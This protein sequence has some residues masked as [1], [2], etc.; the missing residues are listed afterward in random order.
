MSQTVISPAQAVPIQAPATSAELP[1]TQQTSALSLII[2]CVLVGLNLR[3]ALAAIGPVVTL[4][5]QD[6]G[7]SFS[8]VA[9]L[10]LLPVLAM[11]IGC[12]VTLWLRR[13]ISLAHL[14]Q[15]ALALLLLANLLRLIEAGSLN[16]ALLL[17]TALLAG[18]GIAVIQAT[19]P[20]VIK[21]LA[22]WRA[23][24]A[25][26]AVL[27]VAAF[28][29]WIRW[30]ARTQIQPAAT[31]AEPQ[32]ATDAEVLSARPAAQSFNRYRLMSLVATFSMAA[33][34]YVCVLAWLPPF[35]I[36][37]GYSNTESGL[38]LG[39]LT[40]V[41]VI[42]GLLFP[43]WAAGSPDRR[44]VLF[45]VLILSIGGFIWL[46]YFPLTGAVPLPS[47]AFTLASMPIVLIPLTLLGLGIGGQF[48][49]IMIVTMDHHPDAQQAGSL[50][51]KVQG[52]G[53]SLAAITPLIMGSVR[54]QLG[55]FSSAWL[56]LAIMYAA[57][58]LL[59]SRYNPVRYPQL[60]MAR[61]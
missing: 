11:G 41:E 57:A 8:G 4:L 31:S 21:S 45:S 3:P 39:Y 23:A 16:A 60:L 34:G 37:L 28:V 50:I 29:A 9:W 15:G 52:Y 44:R 55:N 18:S 33:A 27:A 19:L 30:T 61:Q 17:L 13:H 42:A 7:L 38:M 26:W 54:D 56:A 5:Q 10:T 32:S 43:A 25:F 24:L 6:T 35:L 59:C 1:P 22:S 46:A 48:R 58:L 51:S 47:A 40:A 14:I 12:F 20:I 36:D 2:I 53:Y 49:M